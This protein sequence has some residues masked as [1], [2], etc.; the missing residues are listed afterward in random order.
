MSAVKTWAVIKGAARLYTNEKMVE[1]AGG[2]LN[3]SDLAPI[4]DGAIVYSLRKVRGKEIPGE[5]LWS[6]ETR[7]I[8]KKFLKTRKQRDLQKKAC[9]IPGLIDA[10]THLV[11]AGDRS[12]EFIARTG[13]VT[14]DE[15]AKMGGG[16]QASVRATRA[17][18]E[19]D[20]FRIAKQRVKAMANL[21]VRAIEMK[22]GYGL[23]Q[24]TELK[25]LRVMKRIEEAFPEFYFR[26][27]Y[28][29]AHAIPPGSTAD[30][31]VEE[32]CSRIL[33][34]IKKGNL[35]H[36]VDIFVDEGYFDTHHARQL[37]EAAQRLGLGFRMHAD[38]LGNTGAAQAAAKAGALSA[39]HLLKVSRAGITALSG[40][41]TVA[42]LLPGTAYFLR[43]PHAPARDLLDAGIRVA[44]AS[45]FN[46]GSCPSFDLPMILQMAAV[47]YRMNSAELLAAVTLN[48]AQAVGA[49]DSL[50]ALIPGRRALFTE[51]NA[52]SFEGW[53]YTLGRWS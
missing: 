17:A 22:S 6:G 44:I 33:P 35:A 21:G 15:L 27:T 43:A 37:A 24:A 3:L 51:L 53:L 48:A 32:I 28:M 11:F 38:E 4:E 50:G 12:D 16:I 14:Y 9:L 40:S 42:I 31:W 18:S 1:R 7:R 47:H 52:L 20:L 39:D 46:P 36:D 5:I 41:R 19:A 34:E 23:D 29:G 49:K 8:P 13:G 10:H 45:D 2:R 26:R 25:Q 30:A